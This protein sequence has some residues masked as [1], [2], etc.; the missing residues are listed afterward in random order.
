M[1]GIVGVALLVVPFALKIQVKAVVVVG[2]SI[3]LIGL[4]LYSTLMANMKLEIV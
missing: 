1:A 2:S 3:G 4:G